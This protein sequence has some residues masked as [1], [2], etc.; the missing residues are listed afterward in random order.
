MARTPLEIDFI[1]K[2]K[3]TARHWSLSWARI[4]FW[5]FLAGAGIGGW[6]WLSL[7][8]EEALRRLRNPEL[9]IVRAENEALARTLERY[10][11][12]AAKIKTGL[13]EVRQTQ[14]RIVGLADIQA[15]GEVLGERPRPPA[16]GVVALNKARELLDAKTATKALIASETGLPELP[17]VMPFRRPHGVSVTFG[18]HLDPF[19]GRTAFHEGIDFPG[20]EGDTVLA[21][22]RGVVLRTGSDWATGTRLVLAHAHGITTVYAHLDKTLVP[23][24]RKV[25][26]GTPIALL[27]NSGRSSGP[28]LHYEIRR[29]G[30]PVDP[31]NAI[32]AFDYAPESDKEQTE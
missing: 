13:E 7:E 17:V 28:H 19:T 10:D 2:G 21:P 8:G 14:E 16:N 15:R 26:R 27:G 29:D 1:P 6:V 31:D 18:P 32:I 30:S 20:N 11:D 24:G 4:A 22:A 23:A 25:E 3:G 12:A 5:L 9:E